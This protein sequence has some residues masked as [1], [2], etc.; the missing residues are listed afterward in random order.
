M[1]QTVSSTES[2]FEK[3]Q[4]LFRPGS[5]AVVGASENG[6][7]GRQVID[8]LRQL[9]YRGR[10]CPV[11]PKY[12]TI[13]GLRCYPSLTAVCEA[14]ERVDLVAILLGSAQVVPVLREAASIGVRAAWAFAS[15]FGEA[16]EAGRAA[17]EELQ[18]VCRDAGIGFIG[19][20]CVGFL[21]PAVGAGAYSAPMPVKLNRGHIGLVAQSG[22]LSIAV[23]NSVRNLG[24][25]LI[26]STGNESVIDC[27]DCMEYMLEDP[28]TEVI[29][30]FVEQF[31][32]PDKLRRVAARAAAAKKPIVLVKVGRTQMAQ[33]ATCAHTGAL[34]GAD[35]IQ[36]AAFRKM[37]IL[38]VNSLDE[39]FE[40][41][42]LFF[43]MKHR[44]T[45]GNGVFAVTLSGGVIS[46]LA[47][48]S[49]DLD[50]R[51]PSWSE[52]G[53][54]AVNAL[55]EPYSHA[56][57]PLDAWDCGRIDE[58]YEGCAR[59]AAGEPDADFLLLVQ[60]VPPS[61]AKRQVEQYAVVARAAVAAAKASGKPVALLCN[62]STSFHKDI[63]DI[64]GEGNVPILQGSREGLVAVDRFLRFGRFV[65]QASPA[66]QAAEQ[67]AE[68]AEDI[69]ALSGALTEYESKQ[70]LKQYGIP[71]TREILCHS[72]DACL[73]AA[74]SIGYPIVLKVMSPDI[75]H[76]TDAGVLAI[77][78]KDEQAVRDAYPRLLERAHAFMSGAR[79]DGMLVQAMA[80]K[81][82]A[83]VIAGIVRD[84]GFGPAVVIGLGGIFVEVLKDRALGIPPL[85]HREALDLIRSLKG[86][87]L[88]SG[89]RGQ[90]KGD[91]EALAEVLM[92]VGEMA[93]ANPDRIETLDINPLLVYPEGQG[94]L[95]VDA[96]LELR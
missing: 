46:M 48:L 21:N 57:N 49:D 83:E 78:L 95:A 54:A 73:D 61:M 79:I 77:G 2:A 67:A 92:R 26:A 82:V 69:E 50:L 88:L 66:A 51:F 72:P 58:H 84:P 23:A 42:E 39:M 43:R 10:I 17:Q 3:L 9:G 20:N 93:A 89:F 7:P 27:T 47:D 33:R 18:Q 55:L 65:H 22:Y 6:G 68:R 75:L 60:D 14:G 86:Y 90:P 24:F 70:V 37:G 19:P 87:R 45:A 4:P 12:E 71:C 74:G 85:S 44:L 76:K 38:R 53:E 52:R 40:T 25:S 8:N 59:A 32:R 36:D 56:N 63:L 80:E 91:V 1:M 94:V 81:P 13:Q 28:E 62:T 35:D 34:A 30:A 31:R 11:N 64:L 15:G 5:I 41:A 16:G 29:M 96:L